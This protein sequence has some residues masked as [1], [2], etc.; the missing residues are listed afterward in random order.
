[1]NALADKNEENLHE[2]HRARLKKRFL[3]NGFEGFE[4]HQIL[5]FFLFY[6]CPRKDTNELAHRL[7]NRFGN[8][9]GVFS[10]DMKALTSVDGVSEHTATLLRAI[11]QLMKCYS[12]ETMKERSFDNCFKLMELFEHSFD[13]TV[14]EEFRVACFDS[15]LRLTANGLISVGT[16]SASAVNMRRIAEFILSNNSDMVAFSH[17]HPKGSSTP[18]KADV[19]ATRAI[20][21]TLSSMGI[22]VMD[23]IVVGEDGVR[24]MRQSGVLG[25]FD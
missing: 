6:S 5:E 3:E 25:V 4:I 1:M 8:L 7:L 20:C 14:R 16:P 21:G 17:N 13:G 9:P 22:T 2:G 11:P 18:S 19:S 24:S 10:A 23:H 15:K 12:T